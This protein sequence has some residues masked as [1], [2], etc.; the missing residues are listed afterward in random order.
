MSKP[1]ELTVDKVIKGGLG[2]GRLPDGQVVMVPRVLPGERVR[3]QLR[4]QHKQYQEAELLEVLQSSAQRIPPI[5]P[6]YDTCGGCD[7]QHATYEEQLRLKNGILGE[8]LCRAGLCR[9]EKLADLLGAPLASPKPFGYR[10][11]IR[12]QVAQGVMG[13]FGRQSHKMIPVSRCPLAG[14]GINSVLAALS[15]NREFQSLLSNASAIELLENPARNSVILLIHYPRKTRPAEHQAAKLLCQALP[16]LEAVLFNVEGQAKGPYFTER[17]EV[18]PNELRVEFSL[19]AGLCGQPVTLGLEPGGFC[20]VNLGQNEN[21]IKLLL[22]W[23]RGMQPTKALD[24]FCGMGNFSL[25]LAMQG[26]D[27]TGMDMQRSTIRSAARNAE[28]AGLADR[29]RFSQESAT[30]AARRLLAEKATFDCLLLDPPR[31]GCADLIPL[32]QDLEAQKIIYISCDPATL[33][34]DLAGLIR[35]GY[36]LAEVRLVDMFP[37]TA[38]QE[39]MARLERE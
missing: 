8:T 9:E 36:R 35:A 39:T 12:L 19:P 3:V 29:C 23:T 16:L 4:R 10:Q 7:F 15:A 13:Y 27:V 1:L 21:C 2:L 14:E 25:P 30:K 33:A 32:L 6:V 11:R 28:A 31:S 17:G 20:Q 18:Q 34:R 24:L 22:E 37:Q 38:H 5:C 26:W